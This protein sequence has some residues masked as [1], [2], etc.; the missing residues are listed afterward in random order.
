V[1]HED[2]RGRWEAVRQLHTSLGGPHHIKIIQSLRVHQ[3]PGT[4]QLALD[5]G[6]TDDDLDDPSG[7]PPRDEVD[8]A[9]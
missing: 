6:T 2:L 5:A 7:S 8:I 4:E 1:N 3:P 9:A